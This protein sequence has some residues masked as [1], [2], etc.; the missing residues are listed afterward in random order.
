MPC[1]PDCL[2]CAL[3]PLAWKLAVAEGYK[4]PK[5]INAKI[6]DVLYIVDLKSMVS[7]KV[8]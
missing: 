4:M 3:N 6:T 8:N 1:V 7:R 2:R 5:P